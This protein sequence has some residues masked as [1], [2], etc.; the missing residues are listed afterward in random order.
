MR[1]AKPTRPAR[2]LNKR[3]MFTRAAAKLRMKGVPSRAHATSYSPRA[4]S[5]LSMSAT[6]SLIFAW[7]SSVC[8]DQ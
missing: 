7:I 6:C 5:S 1:L 2:C 8:A 4:H 3:V